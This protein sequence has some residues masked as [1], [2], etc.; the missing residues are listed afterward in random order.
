[1]K[2]SPSVRANLFIADGTVDAVK[3]LNTIARDFNLDL[4]IFIPDDLSL[5][6]QDLYLPCFAY[7]NAFEI[8]NVAKYVGIKHVITKYQKERCIYFD[9]DVCFYGDIIDAIEQDSK[10]PIILSSHQLL[11]STDDIESE[12]LLHGWINSGFSV[13]DGSDNRVYEVL[14]WLIH[15]IAIRGYLAPQFGLSGDQPWLSGVPFIF[16]DITKITKHDGI[17]VAYWNISERFLDK[18]NEDL[19]CNGRKL[20]LFHFS[21]FIG[22]PENR[23][24]K[25]SE[26]RVIKGS[27]L[28]EIC[29]GYRLELDKVKS[30]FSYLSKVNV[31]PC[32]N[33][34]LSERISKG[35]YANGINIDSPTIRRGIFSRI[36]GRFDVLTRN[37]VNKINLLVSR[38]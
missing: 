2:Y 6:L 38:I 20:I 4:N 9:A 17:N 30:L 28:E 29:S 15:R 33:A 25:H 22:A 27:V 18:K 26:V 34:N 14:D 10:S 8:S 1:M 36:G 21:G 24:S 19:L 7:Y 23:L 5:T 35:S 31:L 3:E 32:S 16:H 37:L 13:F 12:Y 11:P